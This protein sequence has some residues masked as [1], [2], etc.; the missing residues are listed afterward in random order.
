MV[1]VEGEIS[2]RVFF[3]SIVG[4]IFTILV[5]YCQYVSLCIYHFLQINHVILCYLMA[6]NVFPINMIFHL[7]GVFDLLHPVMICFIQSTLQWRYNERYDV[8]NH[9]RLDCL[10]NRLFMRR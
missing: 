7:R 8:L 9:R 1:S 6:V 5:N 3:K 10:L 2:G 4:V